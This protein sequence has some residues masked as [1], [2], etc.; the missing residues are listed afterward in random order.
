VHKFKS[1]SKLKVKVRHRFSRGTLITSP[2]LKSI[3]QQINRYKQLSSQ[4]LNN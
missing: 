1:D 4:I 3:L 2:V